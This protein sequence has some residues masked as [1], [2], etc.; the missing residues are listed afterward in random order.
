VWPFC[1]AA[2]CANY[3]FA[4]KFQTLVDGRYMS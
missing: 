2:N 3:F 4:I 1:H